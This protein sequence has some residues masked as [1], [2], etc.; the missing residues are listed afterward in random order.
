ME[1]PP[2]PP[3]ITCPFKKKLH[4][5]LWNNFQHAPFTISAKC[6]HNN[7][8]YIIEEKIE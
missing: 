8:M 3:M 5:H 7:Y 4:L 2:E 6:L 1:Y